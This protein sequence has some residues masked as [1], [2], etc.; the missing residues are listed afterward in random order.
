MTSFLDPRFKEQPYLTESEKTAVMLNIREELTDLIEECI[1]TS[2][3]PTADLVVNL[4]EDP[5]PPK[6]KGRVPAMLGELFNSCSEASS[7]RTACR[8]TISSIGS[9]VYCRRTA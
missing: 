1:T 2:Y 8:R 7:T 3:P 6:K 5:P 4:N 9:M